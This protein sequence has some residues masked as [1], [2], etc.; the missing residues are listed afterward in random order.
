MLAQHLKKLKSAYDLTFL[1]V[2]FLLMVLWN[3]VPAGENGHNLFSFCIALW[4]G[5]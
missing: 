1:G 3:I 5:L 2:S 4:A